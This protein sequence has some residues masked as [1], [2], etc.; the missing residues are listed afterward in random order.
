M[1]WVYKDLVYR[2]PDDYGPAYPLSEWTEIQ[3]QCRVFNQSQTA[4][5]REIERWEKAGWEKTQTVCPTRISLHHQHSLHH[6]S[7]DFFD[8]LACTMT[9]GLAALIRRNAVEPEEFRLG[10]KRW[11]PAYRD[12]SV[13]H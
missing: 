4:I 9:L 8:L 11:E 3:I 6:L 5:K 1:S 12:N 13:N 2:Y 10:M 7:W